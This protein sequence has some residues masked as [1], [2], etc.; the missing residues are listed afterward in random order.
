MGLLRLPRSALLQH[1]YLPNYGPQPNWLT[2]VLFAGL[3]Q[4]VSP[5]V[6]EKLVLSGYLVLLPLAFRGALPRSRRGR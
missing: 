2:Q 6:A 5:R 3:V 4:V 1:Y